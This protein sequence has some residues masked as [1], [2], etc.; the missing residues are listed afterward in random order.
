MRFL[1][2]N[3][4]FHSIVANLVDPLFPYSKSL[5]LNTKSLGGW[6]FCFSISLWYQWHLLIPKAAMSTISCTLSAGHTWEQGGE[7][8]ISFSA[9]IASATVIW[10]A[11]PVWIF[12]W[13]LFSF[14]SF[15]VQMPPVWL[16]W[17]LLACALCHWMV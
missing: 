16:S 4:H 8:L 13:H 11:R 9:R 17:S 2:E 15:F 3:R 1:S 10:C 5:H 12:F 6:Q 7:Q 14:V